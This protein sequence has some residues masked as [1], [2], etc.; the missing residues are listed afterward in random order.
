MEDNA[1]EE[2]TQAKAEHEA[3]AKERFGFHE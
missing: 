1:V 2:A 3:G